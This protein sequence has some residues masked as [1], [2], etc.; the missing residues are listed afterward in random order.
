MLSDNIPFLLPF[1]DLLILSKPLRVRKMLV[2]HLYIR[3]PKAQ[4]ERTRNCPDIAASLCYKFASLHPVELPLMK[5]QEGILFHSKLG[6]LIL[7]HFFFLG[8]TLKPN[9]SR[10]GLL[11]SWQEKL[12]WTHHPGDMLYL[13]YI[14]QANQTREDS[15]CELP[16]VCWAMYRWDD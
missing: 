1:F 6:D 14:P 7:S 11:V 9:G 3:G 2:S 10:T 4:I 5:E 15:W 13:L 8:S 12:W 16:F